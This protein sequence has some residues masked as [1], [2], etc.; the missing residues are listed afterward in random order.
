M[1]L[2]NISDV[3][4]RYKNGVTAIYDLD[5]KIKKGEFVFVIGGSGSGKST[6][7]KM[8]Y[9]EEKPTK[10]QII[11]GGI[12]V[13]KLRNSKVYKLR[14]RLGIVF[15]DYRLLPKL[16]VFENVAFA[17]EVLGAKKDET[18]EKTLKA[19]EMVGLKNKVHNYPDQLSGG[20]QQRV[21]I[22]RAIVNDPKLLLCDEPTG[23]LDPE[24][25]MEIMKV[26]EDINKKRGTTILMVTHD[27][28]IVN[29]M[30]KQ[31]ITLKDGRL[32]NNIEKGTY[33]DE[34]I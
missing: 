23:N 22:A 7:I 18:R 15:Q 27:K 6:L 8:L 14:R 26:L 25:S 9:R 34:D 17:M 20:E 4:K 11:I 31:V 28:D 2:I 12:N 3:S 29:K 19:I 21:A 5:L 33:N 30:K 16:T 32:V 13:A 1:E 24:M 10:G